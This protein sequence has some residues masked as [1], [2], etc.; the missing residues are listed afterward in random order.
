MK[1]FAFDTEF[2]PHG[3]VVGGPAPKYVSRAEA[4]TIAASARA[5][6]EA[7]TMASGFAS[8]D[9]VVRQ[10]APVNPQ[11][12]RIA[13]TLR[14]EAAELALIAARKI[15]GRALDAHGAEQAAEAV[16]DAVRLLK[17]SPAII[18]S[19]P[20]D[21]LGPIERRLEQ[22][23]KDGRAGAISFRSDPGAKPGDW[24]VEWGEGLVGFSRDTVEEAIE[25]L[26]TERLQDPVHDQ[27]DLFSVA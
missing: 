5:E 10:L 6:A 8:V 24:R 3:D 16:A 1:A 22:L 18:V 7:L 2:T 9:R 14:R 21:A 27:L 12:V 20:A 4:E 25:A 19:A 26:L 11:I 13:E 17:G 15:A 23:K